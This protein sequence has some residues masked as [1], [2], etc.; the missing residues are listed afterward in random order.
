MN[1]TD[2]TRILEDLFAEALAVSKAKGAAYSSTED[3]LSNFKTVSEQTGTTPF[4]V[5]SVYFLKH[6]ISVLNAIK[7]NPDKPVEKTESLRGRLI[8]IIVYAGILEAMSREEN[9]PKYD[10]W[11][12]ENKE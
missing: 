5:W 7:Q 2:R 9:E 3:A 6:V 11:T 1:L 10:L 12:V 4:Q 8:D